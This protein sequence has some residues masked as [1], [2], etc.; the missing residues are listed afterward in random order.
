MVDNKEKIQK[1]EIKI[2]DRIRNVSTKILN[3]VHEI[4]KEIEDKEIINEISE[5]MKIEKVEATNL[6][7]SHMIEVSN[8]ALTIAN[9]Y[10]DMEKFL[11]SEDKEIS[12]K[13]EEKIPFLSSVWNGDV[14][15]GQ[16]NEGLNLLL[17]DLKNTLKK[18]TLN[19]IVEEIV[20]GNNN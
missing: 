3:N 5:R 7:Q 14:Y 4:D 19:D 8:D 9:E 16:E 20:S 2:L 13:D 17:L 11:K 15:D 18:C 6:I 12:Q 1:L 10:H